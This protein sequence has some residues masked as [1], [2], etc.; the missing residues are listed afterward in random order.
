MR[1]I[2]IVNHHAGTLRNGRDDGNGSAGMNGQLARVQEVLRAEGIDATV[3]A[4]APEQLEQ[5]A[6][7]AAAQRPD[8]VIAAGGDGTVSAVAAALAGGDVPLGVLPM[9]TLNHFARDAGLPLELEQ[10]ARIIAG[11]TV[12]QVDVAEVNGR[13]F[14][15]NS[16]IGL[17]PRIVHKRD[18]I[19]ER[20]GRSKWAAMLTATLAILRRYPT[21]DLRIQMPHACIIR[22]APAVFVGNNPYEMNLLNLGRRTSLDCGKLSV[23]LTHHTGRFGL[24]RL[25]LRGLLGRLDQDKDFESALLEEC[26]IETPKR[27]L[28]VAVDGEVTVMTPPLDYKVRPGAL[29]LI[30]RIPYAP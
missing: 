17:Y 12:R 25:A 3:L 24:F 16:S 29:K 20:L 7:D 15:N 1:T 9:G 27:I 30:A 14:I 19:R 26:V 6:R 5:A 13:I 8:V 18:E 4:V 21:L 28:R 11:R 22:K 10:A 23:Y 2:A